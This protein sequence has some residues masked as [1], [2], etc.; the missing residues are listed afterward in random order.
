MVLNKDIHEFDHLEVKR[1]IFQKIYDWYVGEDK[2]C[3]KLLQELNYWKLRAGRYE[4]RYKR[5]LRSS[6][7][8]KEE[9]KKIK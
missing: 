3:E 8:G 9:K 5:M 6:Q 2:Q 7:N 1:N 4:K